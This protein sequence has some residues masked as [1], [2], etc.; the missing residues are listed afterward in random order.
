[1]DLSKLTTNA[2][3]PS[4]NVDAAGQQNGTQD[5]F[6][7]ILEWST[8]QP[9]WQRDA[10]RRL[11]TAGNLSAADLG[12][13]V[14]LC[15]SPH[16]LGKPSSPAPLKAE[17]VA[18]SSPQTVPVSVVSVTHRRGVNALAPEQTIAFGP[19][20]TVVYSPNA[21]GKSGYTRIL[22]RACRSRGIEDILGNVLSGETPLK[23]HA[24]IRYREGTTEIP[25]DWGPDSALSA[26][27]ASVSV[28]DSHCA[29]VYLRDKTDVAFRPF[30][31]DI[32]DKLSSVCA[33]VRERLEGE[34]QKINKAIPSLPVLAE[35]TAAKKVVDNLTA[36]TKIDDLRTLAALS[37]DEEHRLKDLQA[38]R[39]DFL[40]ADLKQRSRELKLK[41]ER[42]IAVGRHVEALSQAFGTAHISKLR[43]AA[44]GVRT[45]Q[46]ALSLVREAATTSDFLPGT[47]GEAWKNMWQAVSCF[48]ELAYPG[49][50]FPALKVG[51]HC[52]FCQQIINEETA[53]RLKHFAEYVTSK[54]QSTLHSAERSYSDALHVTQISIERS[55]ITL[56]ISELAAD[57]SALAQRITDLLAEAVQIQHGVENAAGDSARLPATGLGTSPVDGLKV[58]VKGLQD[59][60]AQLDAEKA[61]LAPTREAELRELEA[62]VTLRDGLQ[63]VLDEVERKKRIGAYKQCLDDTS[64]QPITR[65]STELTTRLVTE[66]LRNTFKAEL[67]AL[68]F[69]HLA[70]E[71]QS[72]GG[73]KGALFHR[74]AFAN[75]PGV[76]VSDVL[77]EGES[78]TLS[79]A[80]FLTELSTASS[81]SAIIFDDP[82]SSLDHTW[83]ER[84]ARRLVA[85]AGKRQ[86]IVFTHDLLFLRLMLDEANRQQVACQNQYVRR[87]GQAGICSPDLP[88]IAAP[89]KERIGKLRV[90]WQTADKLQRT[91]GSEAYESAAR[92]M[93][94]L[95]R[96]T[97]E[98]AVS[99]VLL[100]DVV[101][102]YRPSIE[103]QKLR[104][105]HDITE[106]DTEIVERA[107]TECSRWIRGHDHPAADGTPVPGPAEL[108]QRIDELENWVKAVRQR[109]N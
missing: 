32:F 37:T 106:G 105:L 81:R 80:A 39:R 8:G 44:D 63:G 62:R 84:I 77:S 103:T 20:L 31:L 102:R 94:G 61:S 40:S 67:K 60:A 55:D 24:T 92:E 72:A 57:D 95:L 109:R 17:H 100:N 53:T 26:A 36:L 4:T 11:F 88:W 70:V 15:K 104:P 83:R 14:E 79:L 101:E 48:S 1:M 65:K 86:V 96:E 22:K 97:W 85:E 30:G 76:A 42:F 12:E 74:L 27:L 3:A 99:E 6:A 75:A 89:V 64:T 54:A 58:A 21:A 38:Q 98:K 71:V 56:A 90:R 51:D 49:G 23:A 78:R 46:Q 28:F 16:G 68:E 2:S 5:V 33:E 82:V 18:I 50:E 13:L 7:E 10:L 69:T 73:A 52:P 9:G 47:G 107:M 108:K 34:L 87:D 66:N 19:N 25:L 45:A 91:S 93:Y 35:G 43:T 59:R 29:S 41:A